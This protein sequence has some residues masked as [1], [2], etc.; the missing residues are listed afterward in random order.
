MNL[1]CN[2]DMNEKQQIIDTLQLQ[3]HP[4]GGFYRE[5][6]RS[7][8]R[9]NCDE[10]ERSAGTCIYFMIDSGNF[11][12]FHRLKSDEAWF[13]HRGSTC[14]LHLIHPNG[15]LETITCGPNNPQV[16]LPAG[17]W[18]AANV[19]GEHNYCLVSCTVWPGFDFDDFEMATR[20]SLT[21]CFPE[22]AE[23]IRAFTR[24]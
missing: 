12:A 3:P 5:T 11:S 10:R 21:D 17:T 18:F 9:I 8:S 15:T 4:E 1:T 20:A 19:L 6:F 2:P 14:T 22:H 24:E 16:I 23:M 7:Q 13:W